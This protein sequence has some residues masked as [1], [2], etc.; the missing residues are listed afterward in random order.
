MGRP[1]TNAPLD[2]ASGVQWH[3]QVSSVTPETVTRPASAGATF[4]S[5]GLM[6]V[7]N[8]YLLVVFGFQQH[9][10]AMVM[11]IFGLGMFLAQVLLFHTLECKACTY[12]SNVDT[13]Q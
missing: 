9:E 6:Q 11:V 8:Q 12:K 13:E 3:K 10:F 7:E 2:E 5:A 1:K 4:V